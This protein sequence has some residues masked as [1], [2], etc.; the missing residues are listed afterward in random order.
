MPAAFRSESDRLPELCLLDGV[1]C[2]SLDAH[3]VQVV[4]DRG[5]FG[6]GVIDVHPVVSDIFDIGVHGRDTADISQC[7]KEIQI[8]ETVPVVGAVDHQVAASFDEVH[9]VQRFHPGL[10]V[11]GEE[12][13]DELSRCGAVL[14]QFHVVLGAVEN[15]HIDRPVI[16]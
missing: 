6:R 8:P 12:R 9:R 5:D 3:L 11:L 15:L 4:L 16:R 14:V 2:G 7:V 13:P 1:L 10:I